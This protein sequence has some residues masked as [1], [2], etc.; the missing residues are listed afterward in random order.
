M[1]LQQRLKFSSM[2]WV[3]FRKFDCRLL[4]TTI[5]PGLPIFVSS[6]WVCFSITVSFPLPIPIKQY[7]VTLW[8]YNNLTPQDGEGL[9]LDSKRLWPYLIPQVLLEGGDKIKTCQVEVMTQRVG[10]LIFLA[11][12][13]LWKHALLCS[14][15]SETSFHGYHSFSDFRRSNKEIVISKQGD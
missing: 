6:D 8:V 15:A 13:A 14:P 4:C 1:F 9:V 11:G 7:T 5:F 3:L 10:C 12:Q 2:S